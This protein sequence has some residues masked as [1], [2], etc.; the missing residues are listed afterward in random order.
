MFFK[1]YVAAGAVAISSF[2]SGAAAQPAPMK[3][4]DS[5]AQVPQTTYDSA[6]IG[7]RSAVETNVSPAQTWREANA[8]VAGEGMH[9]GGHG[10]HSGAQG[11]AAQQTPTRS[12]NPNAH[13]GH[14]APVNDAS[15]E[16]HAGH[17]VPN[18]AGEPSLTGAHSNVPGSSGRSAAQ[19][20]TPDPHAG[21]QMPADS[22]TAMPVNHQGHV[23]PGNTAAP[24]NSQAR[25]ST[26]AAK[27]EHQPDPHAG[28]Q[29]P[30]SEKPT[31]RAKV[32]GRDGPV[33][34]AAP[35][36]RDKRSSPPLRAVPKSSAPVVADPHA[37]HQMPAVVPAPSKQSAVPA[38]TAKPKP[39]ADEHQQHR[40]L[41]EK[42]GKK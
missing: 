39:M 16:S 3:V 21:H 25:P 42:G 5:T 17:G 37:G 11:A 33:E 20:G 19:P 4:T 18:A 40:E 27:R 38:K 30:M 41:Q 13:A 1:N 24:K 31:T 29:M 32:P 7:Y 28:H 9:G 6:F 34:A 10:G 14:G 36:K 26:P 2:A 8:A 23:M 22:Q 35:S 15:K 12:E